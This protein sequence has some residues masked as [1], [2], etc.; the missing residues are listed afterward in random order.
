MMDQVEFGLNQMKPNR[1]MVPE[2]EASASRKPELLPLTSEDD[3]FFA[4][5]GFSTSMSIML[6]S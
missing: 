4:L 6:A 2:M 5:K 3:L 1:N